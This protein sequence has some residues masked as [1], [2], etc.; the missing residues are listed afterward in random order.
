[1]G[2]AQSTR[3]APSPQL[4]HIIVRWLIRETLG[5]VMLAVVLFLAAGTIGWAAGW[6]VVVIMTGWVIGTALVVIPRYPELLAERL[7]PK[8]GGKPWD[9]AA[10]SVYGLSMMIMWIVGGLD[11]RYGWSV[12]IGA[13]T[14]LLTMLGMIAGHAL[15]VW[16]TS[17]N[18]FFSQVVR[19]QTERGHTVVSNGPYRLVRHPAYSGAVLLNLSAPFLLGS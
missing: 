19:I 1:M 9:M 14:Q 8:K 2:A 6:A 3:P 17:V 7:G 12:G 15:I 4:K 10:L 18:A 13:A 11:R 5:V 16:A